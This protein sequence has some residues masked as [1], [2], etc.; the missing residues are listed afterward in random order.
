MASFQLHSPWVPKGDQPAAIQSLSE[1]FR[2]QKTHQTLLGV[3]GSGKTFVMANIIQYLQQPTLVMAP[4][5]TLAA[6]LYAEFKSFFPDNAI[7]YFV[8]YYDFYQ[9]EAYIPTRDIYIEKD[10]SIN[11]QIDRLRLEA[12]SALLSRRDVVIIASVSCIYSLGDP[13]EYQGMVL[14]LQQDSLC[15]RE[16]LLHRLV[17]MQ[18][19][20]NDF[21]LERGRFR[22]RGDVVEIWPGYE[23]RIIRLELFG[24]KLDRLTWCHP[25]DNKVLQKTTQAVLYPAKHYCLPHEKVV[26]A[27][28]S[29]EE[30]LCGRLEVLKKEEKLLE[31]N[32]LE[33]RTRYDM[34]M[35]REVG[36]CSGIENYSRHFS[37]RASG[38]R[39]YCLLDY[40]PRPYLTIV[41]ESHISVP[42]I[43]G[44]C[45]GDRSRKETLVKYGF[46]LPSALDNRPLTLEEWEKVTDKVLFVSATPA[47]Y[48]ITKS[49]GTVVEQLV[50]PTGLVDPLVEVYPT[51]EQIAHLMALIQEKARQQERVLVTTLTKRL[52]EDVT[53]FLKQ[54]QIRVA[55]LHCEIDT[56]DRVRI[57]Q[58]LRKGVYDAV[59][60]INLLREG[61]D[62]PEVSL[63]A[64]L[65]ADRE[66]FL[67]SET[68][69]IQTM[70]RAA[71]HK[72]AK[73]VLYADRVTAAMRKAIDETQRRRQ[74]QL[75]YNEKYHIEPQSIHKEILQSIDYVLEESGDSKA[76]TSGVDYQSTTP[77]TLEEQLGKLQEEMATYAANLEFEKAAVVRDKMLAL[78][79]SRLGTVPQH[80]EPERRKKSKKEKAW[81]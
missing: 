8:S 58:E 66:G 36:Y 79:K 12:T 43:K 45:L 41:D 55:Y 6:Q 31:A 76:N 4:N 75:A 80:P 23:E 70:G 50:R 9:P 77:C 17:A 81:R 51:Q 67:R 48:E 20:R 29:I 27:L 72:N 5:K 57:L 13:T 62:L 38:E 3:T 65:D 19:I 37:N 40:F 22:V 15:E 26:D 28:S 18:Y 78:Q 35:L 33:S 53:E 42:Q 54:N 11:D 68:S 59:V 46:R 63:V 1:G 47:A 7:C 69:L 24:D 56:F 64:I 30:E 71:R 14:S 39:P 73:V 74:I 60:G 52:A 21:E 25:I 2:A 44:M 16:E 34:E 32:R 61:L 10:A 49:G